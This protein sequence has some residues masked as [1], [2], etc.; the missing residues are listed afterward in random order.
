MNAHALTTTPHSSSKALIHALKLLKKWNLP[1]DGDVCAKVLGMLL[2]FAVLAEST[3]R[4]SGSKSESARMEA[5]LQL[6]S[7]LDHA[8]KTETED[9]LAEIDTSNWANLT[10]AQRCEKVFQYL[11]QIF[12]FYLD[13]QLFGLQR[14]KTDT[15][16]LKDQNFI[17]FLFHFGNEYPQYSNIDLNELFNILDRLKLFKSIHYNLYSEILNCSIKLS[18]SEWA[19]KLLTN[20]INDNKLVLNNDLFIKFINSFALTGRIQYIQQLYEQL[21]LSQTTLLPIV[22]NDEIIGNLFNICHRLSAPRFARRIWFDIYYNLKFIAISDI[23]LSINCDHVIDICHILHEIDPIEPYHFISSWI[24]SISPNYNLFNYICNFTISNAIFHYDIL[25]II[26]IYRTFQNN[27]QLNKSNDLNNDLFQK[28][29][30]FEKCWNEFVNSIIKFGSSQNSTENSKSA[31]MPGTDDLSYLPLI[32]SNLNENSDLQ[33]YDNSIDNFS[34]RN[35][36]ES[37]WPKLNIKHL[38]K[39]YPKFVPST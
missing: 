8:L 38:Q 13:R 3:S 19:F 32:N 36:C 11:F 18:K 14:Q 35:I 39:K 27:Q 20:L 9:Y 33:L 4:E 15:E 5:S 30:I 26:Q 1:L 21:L 31:N 7:E 37:K 6:R 25:S 34:K 22:V 28:S 10:Q 29:L 23:H 12:S 17:E 2:R 16:I 24:E